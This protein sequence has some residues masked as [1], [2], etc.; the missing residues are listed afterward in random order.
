MNGSHTKVLIRPAGALQTLSQ[1]EVAQL[2]DSSNQGLNDLLKKCALAVLSTG[3]KEDSSKALMSAHPSFEISVIAKGRGLQLEIKCAPNNAFVHDEMIIGLQEHLSAVIRDL[4]Y[5]KNKI[6]DSSEF[7]L[8]NSFDIT[9]A[10]FHFTRNAGLIK[11][12]LSPNIAVCWGGHSISLPEYK[13]TKQVGYHLGLRRL[14]ICTGCGPGAMLGPMKGAVLGHG[15]QRSHNARYIGLTEPGIISAEAPNAIV[16]QL[17]ILPDI[18]KRLEAFVR[19]GH[20][21]IVFPGGAGTLEEILYLLSILL[22]PNNAD[23]PFP[24]ALTAPKE[25]ADYFESVLQFIGQALGAEATQKFHLFIDDAEG[26]ADFM[27][28][29]FEN[30]R[31]YRKLTSE[32]YYYNWH[33]HLPY[34]VQQPFNPTHDSMKGLNLHKNQEKYQL[35]SQLRRA[36]SGIVAG[37]VK[38]NTI[39]QIEKKG[40]FEINGDPEI[41]TLMDKLLANIVKQKRMKLGDENYT[42]CYKIVT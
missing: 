22:H 34:E 1:Y 35:A 8:E 23:L 21:I 14:D 39:I 31:E 32:A 9:N 29:E 40:P 2:C 42:P 20:G 24:V 33:L 27:K 38:A 10:I 36:F 15:K 11:A 16:N 7:D 17:T 41:M 30:V 18:E 25:Y 6:I 4:L 37:N 28:A 26:V 13:Y 5:A 19:L 12:G 3:T